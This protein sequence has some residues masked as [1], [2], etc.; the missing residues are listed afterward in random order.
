MNPAGS[1]YVLDTSAVI[2][3]LEAE[4]GADRVGEILRREN[5]FLPFPVALEL[6]YLT[7]RQRGEARADA[8]HA[9]LKALRVSHLNVVDEA[10]MLTAGRFKA[11]YPL[12]CA[13][14]MIAAFAARQD[15]VLVH[16]D[17]EFEKLRDH[18]K[19][20]RLP[21]KPRGRRSR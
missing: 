16:K 11:L 14:A 1:A 13:D 3:L 5:V 12:S 2:A 6:Y 15:A 7:L 20:E 18:V 8:R 10:T 4:E 9:A 19:Q 17:P 21:Y